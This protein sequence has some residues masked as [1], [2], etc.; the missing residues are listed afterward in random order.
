M[1]QIEHEIV[2]HHIPYEVQMLRAMFCY[3]STPVTRFMVQQW[4]VNGFIETFCVHARNLIDFFRETTDSRTGYA[5]AKHFTDATYK[6][7]K[8]SRDEGVLIGKLNDQIAHVTY[9]R[10]TRDAAK[11]GDNERVLLLRLIEEELARFGGHL[12]QQYKS[13]WPAEMVRERINL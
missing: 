5:A 2:E 10:T 9:R 6:P 4:V 8:P 12:D 13:L 7:F 1:S 3:L 11:I